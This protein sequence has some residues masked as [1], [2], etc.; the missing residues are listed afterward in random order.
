MARSRLLERVAL[1]P[2]GIPVERAL[3]AIDIAL[4]M[5]L[6]LLNFSFHTPSLAG[7]PYS[8]MS[9][10]NGPETFYTWW[11]SVLRISVHAV[12]NRRPLPRFPTLHLA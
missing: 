3:E 11:T 12:W 8:P 5:G 7:W 4:D 2:E 9:A 10:M 1:T 6:P